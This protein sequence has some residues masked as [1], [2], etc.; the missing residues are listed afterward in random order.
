MT[1]RLSILLKTSLD[2]IEALSILE[3]IEIAEEVAEVYGK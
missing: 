3:L 1:I 2:E